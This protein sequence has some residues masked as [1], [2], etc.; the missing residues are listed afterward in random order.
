VPPAA[1][2]PFQL[3]PSDPMPPRAPFSAICPPSG[4]KA[5]FLAEVLR[6]DPQLRFDRIRF[7]RSGGEGSVAEECGVSNS[8]TIYRAPTRVQPRGGAVPCHVSW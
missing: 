2:T 8:D 5:L 4:T 6:R 1:A 3:R 7:E